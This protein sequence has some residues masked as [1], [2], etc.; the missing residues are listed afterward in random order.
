MRPVGARD[1]DAVLKL[2]WDLD[3]EA[4]G[5]RVSGEN[6]HDER[7]W[8]VGQKLFENWWWAFDREVWA[9]S[10]VLRKR[11]GAGRLVFPADAR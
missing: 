1:P 2:F 11:R 9:N 4:E 6:A 5:A 7:N 8:E 3:D 10:N